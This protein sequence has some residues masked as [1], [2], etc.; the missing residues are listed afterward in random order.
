MLKEGFG[1]LFC[2]FA[3]SL[4][5]IFL[6]WYCLNMN[7]SEP[8]TENESEWQDGKLEE[9]ALKDGE[10]DMSSAETS[11]SDVKETR[12]RRAKV[13]LESSSPLSKLSEISRYEVDVASVSREQ[14][15]IFAERGYEIATDDP[16]YSDKLCQVVMETLG[17]STAEERMIVIA[18]MASSGNA[19]EK[20]AAMRALEILWE[21]KEAEVVEEDDVKQELEVKLAVCMDG[22]TQELSSVSQKIEER[23]W[24]ID[25]ETAG[26]IALQACLADANE[27][28]RAAGVQAMLSAP[29]EIGAA[30]NLFVM[31]GED[32]EAKIAV[33]ESHHEPKVDSDITIFMQALDNSDGRVAAYASTTLTEK[34]GRVFSDSSDALEWWEKNRAGYWELNGR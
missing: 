16:H 28:V 7:T 29:M 27:D 33:L 19:E 13:F 20:I 2:W 6:A 4:L 34:L 10:S 32:Y 3:G 9:T 15:V 23:L 14:M 5:A 11:K 25:M 12:V 1:K 26:Q 21:S 8:E 24:D 18:G 22:N 31:S 30:L 17:N